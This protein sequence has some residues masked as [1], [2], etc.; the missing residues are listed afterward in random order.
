MIG[1]PKWFS[2]RKYGGWGLTPNCW[3]GWAY[4]A[5]IALPMII[6]SNLSLSGMWPVALMIVWALIFSIDFI[7]IFL[8]IRKDERDI[9]HEAIAE[10]N[11]MWF[12]VVSLAAGVAYQTATS[13]IKNSLQIDPVIIVALLGATLVKAITNF[14]LRN[15]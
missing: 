15:K 11:A 10:R 3:Q 1:N 13:A 12:M 14:Y 7:D 9:A 5:A 4:I 2:V 8:K 6:I